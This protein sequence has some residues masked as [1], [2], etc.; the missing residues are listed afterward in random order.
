MKKIL[1]YK[2]RN[3]LG[4]SGGIEKMI[5]FLANNLSNHGYTVH[6]AT[7]D[8]SSKDMFFPLE[9]HITLKNK[10]INKGEIIAILAMLYK[11]KMVLLFSLQA[12]TLRQKTKRSLSHQK[13]SSHTTI[14]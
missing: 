8:S 1:I 11:K 13:S 2:S 9:K 3:L 6:I 12:N 5:S 14:L 10:I 4:S 7:H